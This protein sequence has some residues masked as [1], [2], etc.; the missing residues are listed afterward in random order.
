MNLIDTKINNGFW[1]SRKEL[2]K[3]ISLYASSKII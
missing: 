2:N 3:N 1:K